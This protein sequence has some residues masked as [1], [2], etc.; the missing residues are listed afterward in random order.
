M[1]PVCLT[2]NNSD[3]LRDVHLRWP[4]FV[5]IKPGDGTVRVHMVDFERLVD[6]HQRGTDS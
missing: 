3:F 1:P 4:R 2:P 6:A 5:L